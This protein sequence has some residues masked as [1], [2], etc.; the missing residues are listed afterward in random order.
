M[1]EGKEYYM[2]KNYKI[3]L[4]PTAETEKKYGKLVRRI[5][6]ALFLATLLALADLY[7]V[8]I[9]VYLMSFWVAWQ[10]IK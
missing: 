4:T 8:N 9:S 1:T 3:S 7:V 10:V 5:V 2:K 6:F